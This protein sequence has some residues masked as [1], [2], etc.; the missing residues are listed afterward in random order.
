M[1][2]SKRK[3]RD[4]RGRRVADILDRNILDRKVEELLESWNGDSAGDDGIWRTVQAGSRVTR[5]PPPD[6]IE[7]A[8][9]DTLIFELIK[10]GY[11]VAKMSAEELVGAVK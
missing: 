2:G 8:S 4:L 5:K 3:G 11:A 6:P 10:R 1:W 7:E 9:D